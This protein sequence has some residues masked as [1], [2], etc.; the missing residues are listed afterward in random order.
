[1]ILTISVVKV[2]NYKISKL[3]DRKDVFML[4]GECDLAISVV[5][6]TTL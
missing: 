6:V 3:I 4:T 1:M 2:T 5:K